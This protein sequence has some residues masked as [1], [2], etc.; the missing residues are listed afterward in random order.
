L[1]LGVCRRVLRNPSD[2]EDAFQAVF[3]ILARKARSIADPATLGSWLYR[4]AYR[5]A[6]QARSAAARRKQ[7]DALPPDLA[8]APAIPAADWAEL[9]GVLDDEIARLPAKYRVPFVL[10]Y[11]EGRTNDE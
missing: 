10:C 8:A 9:R 11:V 1:V 5:V 2:V 3:I 7:P 6:L 4:V